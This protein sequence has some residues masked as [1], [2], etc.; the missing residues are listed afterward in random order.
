MELRHLH[1]NIYIPE[2]GRN[3]ASHSSSVLLQV[4]LSVKHPVE[5]KS[6]LL[7]TPTHPVSCCLQSL[8]IYK[9]AFSD[10]H[11]EI[12]NTALFSDEIYIYSV[13]DHVDGCLELYSLPAV[14]AQS[15][16]H[17]NDS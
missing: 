10:P 7:L 4:S 8:I 1:R 17:L 16:T 9:T 2:C 13:H 14:I 3:A 15:S 5:N 11:V 12:I 6:T